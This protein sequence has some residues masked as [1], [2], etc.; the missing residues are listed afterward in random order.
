[1]CKERMIK[2]LR[3]KNKKTHIQSRYN[4][5]Q[6]RKG[7]SPV[8]T[9]ILLVALTIGIISI[10]FFWFRGMVQEG[11]VKFGKNIQ[12]ACDDVN[13]EADYSSGTL[14]IINDGNVP[15]FLVNIK[16]GSGGSYQT[17]SIQDFDTEIPWPDVGLSEGGIFSGDIES[18]IDD[19]DEMTIFPILIGTANGQQKTFV[20]EG[21][22]GKK[23]EI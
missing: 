7:L 4:F 21:Q 3:K 23:I 18:E 10:I 8:V 15:I 9:T 6:N 19:A 20:C 13:F 1:M 14:S 16:Y 11:V 17:K 22:Y 5:L 12:L 2:G